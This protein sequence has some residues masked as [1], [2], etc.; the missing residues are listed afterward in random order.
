LEVPGPLEIL[1]ALVLGHVT[2]H[3]RPDAWDLLDNWGRVSAV[4]CVRKS[5][6]VTIS[7]PAGTE[8]TVARGDGRIVMPYDEEVVA[9]VTADGRPPKRR[10]K[11]ESVVLDVPRARQL[12]ARLVSVA[13]LSRTDGA[14]FAAEVARS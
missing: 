8:R 12:L 4:L 9:H 5:G 2:F 1:D 7:L 3:R 10:R 13:G 6:F 14:Q 11:Q